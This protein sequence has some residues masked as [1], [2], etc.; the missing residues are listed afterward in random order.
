MSTK[1]KVSKRR[2][3][4][5]PTIHCGR[6]AFLTISPNGRSVTIDVIA[7]TAI[8]GAAILHASQE[9]A[10]TV[11]GVLPFFGLILEHDIRLSLAGSA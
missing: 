2:S 10:A 9:E 11:E 8:R 7:I 5:Q 3:Q 1:R 6:L 4:K